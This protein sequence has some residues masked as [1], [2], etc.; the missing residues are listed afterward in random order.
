MITL[1]PEYSKSGFLTPMA[2][3]N[4]WLWPFIITVEIG[5][6]DDEPGFDLIITDDKCLFIFDLNV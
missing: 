6:Q 3:S 5:M 1:S 2:F 4:L